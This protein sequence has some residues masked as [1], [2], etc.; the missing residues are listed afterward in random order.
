MHKRGLPSCDVCPSV[1]PT[2]TFVYSVKT[3]KHIIK[4]FHHRVTYTSSFSTPSVMAIFRRGHPNE[5]VECRWVGKNCDSRPISGFIACC[6]RF[7][8]QVLYTQLRR[9]MHATH[10]T[11]SIFV[12]YFISADYV[13]KVR[14][15]IHLHISSLHHSI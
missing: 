3:S 2:V 15:K 6:Q 9:I 10:L 7:D 11:S 14:I 8:R 5:G 13:T 1:C 12:I 4:I